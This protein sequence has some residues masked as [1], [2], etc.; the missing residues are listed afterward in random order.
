MSAATAALLLAAA[1]GLLVAPR[2]RVPRGAGRVGQSLG[3]PPDRRP[4]AR[5]APVLS[6]LVTA[7]VAG[8]LFVLLDGTTLG[9]ALVVAGAAAGGGLLVRRA[10]RQRAAV[11]RSGQVVEVCE[12]LAGD[13]RAGLPPQ[14][15]LRRAVQAW[16]ELAPAATAADLGADVPDAL[17]RLSRLPGASGLAGVAAAWQVAQSSGGTMALAL[18]QVAESARRTRA[19]R[20]LV[21]S[22][23]ASAQATARLVAALPV[24]VLALGAGLGGD[25]WGFLLRTP[26]GLVCLGLGV[27]LALLGLLWIERIA[28]RAAEP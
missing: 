13:L 16:P 4:S 21:A 6:G 3:I 22:E 23:L 1:A 8:A 15:A 28:A 14:R 27:G 12:W 18:G 10:A 19:T 25:P 17:R 11:V 2:A 7:A 24:L 26:P 5:R 20:L 9:L